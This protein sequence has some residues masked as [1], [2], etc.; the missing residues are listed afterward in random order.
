MAGFRLRKDGEAQFNPHLTIEPVVWLSSLPESCLSS[1]LNKQEQKCSLQSDTGRSSLR[2][3]FSGLAA[4]GSAAG[5]PRGG[6]ERN[7]QRA[8]DCLSLSVPP[9]ERYVQAGMQCTEQGSCMHM[10][11]FFTRMSDSLLMWAPIIPFARSSV[12][13]LPA[14]LGF[15]S[16]EWRLPCAAVLWS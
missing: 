3:P 10:I 4:S 13:N 6:G 2:Y 12:S 14:R 5:I 7:Q 9:A 8:S 1:L 15:Q 16:A 11:L